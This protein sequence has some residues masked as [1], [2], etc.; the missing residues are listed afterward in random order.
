MFA[1]IKREIEDAIIFFAITAAAVII[2]VGVLTYN[3][4]TGRVNNPALGVPSIMYETFKYFPL[5]FWVAAA[6]GAMQMYLDKN[7]KTSSFLA[8][9]ST[10]RRQILAAK[11]ITGILWIC[12]V[13]LPVAAVDVILLKVYPRA[14]V[15]DSGFLASIFVVIF[16]CNL[17]C[18]AFG[19]QIGWC[20][21]RLIP[22]LGV[23]LIV[24]ILQSLIV[25]KGLGFGTMVILSLFTAASMIR[26][27]KKFMSVPL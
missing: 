21:T 15:P 12:L 22:V 25:L 13:V 3:V 19:L 11:I 5:F 9:L 4:A 24:P 8:T 16:L 18:Y 10:T 14:V 2:L 23:I 27:W 17:A 26:T 1:L 6:L 20:A 7:K